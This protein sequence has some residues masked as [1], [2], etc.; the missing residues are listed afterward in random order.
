MSGVVVLDVVLVSGVVVLDVVLVSGVVVLVEF[1][2]NAYCGK[3]KIII[4][5]RTKIARMYLRWKIRELPNPLPPTRLLCNFLSKWYYRQRF[6]DL[7]PNYLV[8]SNCKTN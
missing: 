7:Y 2:E 4:E 6:K 5:D 8:S 3:I 1:S